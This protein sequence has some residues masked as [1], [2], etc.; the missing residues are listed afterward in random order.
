ERHRGAYKT[1]PSHIEAFDEA[2]KSLG[3]VLATAAPF[4]TQRLMSELVSWVQQSTQNKAIHPLLAIAIFVVVFLEIHPFQD[5]TG[6][7]SRVLTTLVLLRAGYAYVPYSSLESIIEQSKDSYYLAL[8]R[9]Q[10]TI[11]TAEPD[12]APWIDFFLR[13][14]QQQKRRLQAKIERER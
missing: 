6:R 11:R 2:G 4:D 1:L 9:T 13:A 10:V 7:L 12:W 14:L 5:G 3:V 8:R